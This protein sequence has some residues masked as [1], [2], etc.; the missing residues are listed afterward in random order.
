[1]F[2][3]VIDAGYARQGEE[4]GQP[5]GDLIVLEPLVAWA[6]EARALLHV[7]VVEKGYKKPRRVAVRAQKPAR[8][9]ESR[10]AL[11]HDEVDDITDANALSEVGEDERALACDPLHRVP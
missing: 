2:G 5:G 10:P 4:A 9:V 7:V 3:A 6:D 8:L 1:L 11:H